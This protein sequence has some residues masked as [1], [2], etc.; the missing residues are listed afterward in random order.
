MNVTELTNALHTKINSSTDLEQI[1]LLSKA[2]ERLKLGSVNVVT[3]FSELSAVSFD[4]AAY[5]SLYF[6]ESQSQL[7]ISTGPG[8]WVSILRSNDIVAY[9]WGVATNGRLGTG[10][11]TVRSSPTSVVGGFTD[12]IQVV[13]MGANSLGLRVNGTLWA[14]GSNSVGQ[15]GTGNII[16]RSS[17]TSVIGGYTD[18]IQ[19]GVGNTN[20]HSLAIRANGTAWAWGSNGN[21]LLGDGT[22]A[23][24]SSPVSV[25][26]GFTDW[27]QLTAGRNHSLGL[28]ADGTAWGWGSN[29]NGRI[30]DGTVTNRSSPVSVVG[31]FTDWT[32][33]SA[34]TVHSL[35]VRADGTAW[36]WGSNSFGR[37]GDNTTISRRSPVSVVGGFTDWTQ[38]AAG[39]LH[40]LGLRA[41]GTVWGWGDAGF[42]QLGNN[43][44]VD[45]SSPVSV[46]GGFTDWVSVQ[47]GRSHTVALRSN[48]TTWAWGN[49]AS[50]RLGDNSTINR[51]FPIQVVGGFTDWVQVSAGYDH[52]LALRNNSSI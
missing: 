47:T 52:T 44:I 9:G 28:R 22:T 34:S 25:V 20:Y 2:V 24:K 38:L 39:S 19:V 27:V 8:I 16:S 46:V 15:L 10:N 42:G 43:S 45:A 13:G 33:V 32:Q 18:W 17:P 50:G 11:A 4:L 37:L 30:G 35:G 29:L 12:W 14:W 26:G 3:N 1:L 6:V 7:Y 31:G 41:N 21:G 49:N 36:A 48:G 23:N 40:S 5:G 51:S